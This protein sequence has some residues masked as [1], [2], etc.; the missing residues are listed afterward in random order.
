MDVSFTRNNAVQNEAVFQELDYIWCRSSE[1]KLWCIV[2]VNNST[3]PEANIAKCHGRSTAARLLRCKEA[4]AQWSA[5]EDR[6]FVPGIS[7]NTGVA[8]AAGLS[9]PAQ[10]TPNC[11]KRRGTAI[12]LCNITMSKATTSTPNVI[13]HDACFNI[14]RRAYIQNLKFHAQ[15]KDRL[16]FALGATT[17]IFLRR[18]SSNIKVLPRRKL[19]SNRWYKNGRAG[20]HS[21]KIGLHYE[22]CFATTFAFS[23][24][25]LFSTFFHIQLKAT[26]NARQYNANHLL[27]H[28]FLITSFFHISTQKAK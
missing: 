26:Y 12:L 14:T 16:C 3:E 10:Q 24:A 19:N 11:R 15:G 23:S 22:K 4:D 8:T 13:F 28:H 5:T 9:T 2:D 17:R 20:G 25:R 6:S 27:R 7:K 21:R 1:K 18:Y